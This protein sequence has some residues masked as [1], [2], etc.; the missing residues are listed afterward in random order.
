[1]II[2]TNRYDFHPVVLAMPLLAILVIAARR[3]W[4]WTW[5]RLI[6]LILGWLALLSGWL[7]PL[8]TARYPGVNA[9]ASR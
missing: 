4:I 5:A 3:Q 7:Y 1:M 2:T 6:L 8:L 9:G